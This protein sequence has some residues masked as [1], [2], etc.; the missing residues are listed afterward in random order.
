MTLCSFIALAAVTVGTWNGEWFPSGRAEH[1]AAPEIEAATIQ[2]AGQRLRRGLDAADPTGTNDVILCFNE[3]RGPRVA[4]ELCRA[5]GRT[6]LTVAVVTG[7]RRRDRYDQQQD[8]I[9]TTLP[10]V[11]AD[12][13]NWRP[14]KRETP[15]RGFARARVVFS[16]AV[17]GTVY[18]VHLKSNYGQ[19]DE[20]AALNRAKR[21]R[22]I[23]QLVEQEE[24]SR[25]RSEPVVIAGDFN[26][27][28]WQTSFAEE[29]IFADLEAAGFVNALALMPSERRFTHPGRGKWPNSAL[30]YIM[31][32]NLP[33]RA[34]PVTVSAEG[35]SDHNPVFVSVDL[36]Q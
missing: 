2:V 27:D 18:A 10:V 7:Y 14:A 25:G 13:E 4:E 15:P 33:P 9:A 23:R 21:T 20:T 34:A 12:W 31:L 8:V 5:T 35:V 22:A 26:A 28:R 36:G 11:S 6:N 30:D 24:P 3:M 16:P 32:R 17:T 19:T 29:T 1:R